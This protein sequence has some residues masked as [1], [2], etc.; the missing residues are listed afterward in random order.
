MAAADQAA[1]FRWRDLRK[2]ALSA[3]ILAP[4]A[5]LCIWLGEMPWTLLVAAAI[6]LL[7][8]EWVRLCG[9]RARSLPGVAVPVAVFLAAG[10]AVG[11][12]FLGAVFTLL[13]GFVLTWALAVA[14]RGRALPG[15]PA[16]WLALGVLVIGLAGL[17]LIWLRGHGDAGRANVVF[18]FVVVWASDIGAYLSGRVVGGPKLAPGLSP[19]KTVAGALGGLAFAALAGMAVATWLAP[20][21]PRGAA[22]VAVVLGIATQAGDLFESAFKR[23]F[24]VKDS[25]TLIPGH[26]GL[27]DRLDG[28]LVA[29]PVAALI[30]L[31]H[32]QDAVPL[33][34]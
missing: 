5:M 18:L 10:A 2:R 30:A 17:S 8:H 15:H 13:A 32:G 29:A 22:L 6:A 24:G 11:G 16:V 20:G 3:A 31:A 26:G 1:L 25:G 23:R 19:S 7:T 34:R 4:G 28:L 9:L 21:D 14:M 27:L 33:W 12:E